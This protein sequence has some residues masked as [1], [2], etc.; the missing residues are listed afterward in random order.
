MKS[1]SV[2]ALLF[3]L[4]IGLWAQGSLNKAEALV[5]QKKYKEAVEEAAKCIADPKQQTKP[6]TWYVRALTLAELALN[7]PKAAMAM[8]SFIADFSAA[9]AKVRELDTKNGNFIGKMDVTVELTGTM[10]VRDKM[11]TGLFNEGVNAQG[12]DAAGAYKAFSML[13]DI[14]TSD[15]TIIKNAGILAINAQMLDQAEKQFRRMTQIA[16]YKRPDVYYNLIYALSQQEKK[17]E[18][19]DVAKEGHIKYPNDTELLSTII[20]LLVDAEKMDEALEF[21]KKGMAANAKQ[22]QYQYMAG[23]IYSDKKDIE[24]AIK[25]Y[26]KALEIKP[27]YYEAAFNLGIIYYNKGAVI[28]KD[29]NQKQLNDPNNPLT[30]SIKE[31]MGLALPHLEKAFSLKQDD[32]KLLEALRLI[33]DLLGKKDK[34]EEMK[35]L[36]SKM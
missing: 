14:F 19:L 11:K 25:A 10:S 9:D 5:E 1:I 7:D 13:S 16:D 18:I 23:V 35:T 24:S 12:S 36:I 33:Y 26:E 17:G 27:D 20:N 22:A 31:N 21:L 15:T 6:R 3:L 28:Y 2:F 29:I 4:Q 32:R 34:A 8:P 30:K